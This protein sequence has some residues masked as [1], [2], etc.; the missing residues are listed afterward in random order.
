MSDGA[1]PD[2]I[3][4]PLIRNARGGP[5]ADGGELLVEALTADGQPVRFAVPLGEVKHF[6]SF[7]LVSVAKIAAFQTQQG[8]PDQ[9]DTSPSRPIPTTSIAIGEPEDGEGYLQMTV[10]FVD[11]LFSMPITAFE[12]V[13][14]SMLLATVRPKDKPSA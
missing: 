10:G 2:G 11:L 1:R 6:V 3:G 8:F 13:A 4:F 14:R 5:S 12:P 9:P 7:L